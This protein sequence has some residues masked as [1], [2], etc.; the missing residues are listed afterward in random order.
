MGHN[1]AWSRAETAAERMGELVDALMP[2]EPVVTAARE[3]VVGAG[4]RARK[5]PQDPRR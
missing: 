2:L 3:R 1:A 5:K 4:G